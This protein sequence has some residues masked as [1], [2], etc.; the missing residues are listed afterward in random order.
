MTIAGSQYTIDV[1]AAA[2]EDPFAD[3]AWADVNNSF[4]NLTGGG[5]GLRPNGFAISVMKLTT[6]ATSSVIKSK[7]AVTTNIGVGSGDNLGAAIINNANG[8]LYFLQSNGTSGVIRKRVSGIISSVG[9]GITLDVT[10][11]NIYE[12]WYEPSTGTL[13][14]VQNDIALATRTDTDLQAATL[15]CGVFGDPQNTNGRR[16]GA[17]GADYADSAV[18]IDSITNPLYSTEAAVITV[19]SPTTIPTT[20]NT[21]IVLEDSEALGI[22]LITGPT[23]VNSLGSDVYEID[24]TVPDS[25]LSGIGL[26]FSETFRVL[27]TIGTPSEETSIQPVELLPQ[28]GYAYV[29]ATAVPG[30]FNTLSGTLAIGDQVLYE[31]AGGTVSV[32]SL[33]EIVYTGSD[34]DGISFEAKAW[35]ATDSTWGDWATQSF[36]DTAPPITPSA[37]IDKRFIMEF[38]Q[39]SARASKPLGYQQLTDLS[40]AVPLTVPFGTVYILFKP[41]AQAI[42]FRDDGVNPTASIGYPVAAGSEYI[43]TG[44]SP[45]ALRFIEAAAGATLDV[46]YYGVV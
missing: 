1:T 45:G 43:Y 16:I 19:T 15:C 18:T 12:L 28:T 41:N 25:S 30:D 20:G 14:A 21:T 42:R 31:T 33:L 5:N 17:F 27:L 37:N 6:I 35:D 40:A 22:T 29:N 46:L 38:V 24:F 23:A 10:P 44:A 32:N 4:E 11:G 9:T 26:A 8:D 34:P 13:T 7:I 39:A 2:T 3:A 36:G